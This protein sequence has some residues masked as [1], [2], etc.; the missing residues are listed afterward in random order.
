M[1]FPIYA[2]VKHVTSGADPR[3]IIYI[4]FVAAHLVMLN[5]K[6]QSS[7]PYDFRQD[8]SCFSVYKPM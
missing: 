7:R 4:N 3:G 5:T 2:F 1:F 6:Y 8:F